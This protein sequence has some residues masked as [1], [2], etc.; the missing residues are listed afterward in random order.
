MK[1]LEKLFLPN[2]KCVLHVRNNYDYNNQ[3][4]DS[5]LVQFA[6][7]HEQA[8]PDGAWTVGSSIFEVEDPSETL[9]KL[10]SGIELN[11]SIGRHGLTLYHH[12]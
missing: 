1:N 10:Q 6:S 9:S 7:H 12:H 8:N 2:I 5:P 3:L 4:G 11:N